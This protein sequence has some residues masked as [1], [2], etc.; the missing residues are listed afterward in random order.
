MTHNVDLG[1]PYDDLYEFEESES[2]DL[3]ELQP[4][5]IPDIAWDVPLLDHN[6]KFVL[7][8]TPMHTGKMHQLKQ[9]VE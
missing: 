6:M 5:Y 2:F 3:D 1:S 7:L 9:L 4:T 8:S